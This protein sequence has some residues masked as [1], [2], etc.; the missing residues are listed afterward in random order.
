MLRGGV[1]CGRGE[2]VEMVAQPTGG[3][4]ARCPPTS[5]GRLPAVAAADSGAAAGTTTGAEEVASAPRLR[6]AAAAGLKWRVRARNHRAR[7]R[8]LALSGTACACLLVPSAETATPPASCQWTERERRARVRASSCVRVSV[9]VCA[10]SGD[11]SGTGCDLVPV[12]CAGGGGCGGFLARRVTVGKGGED[13]VPIPMHTRA[14]TH[15]RTRHTLILTNKH[16][17][18]RRIFVCVHA[19]RSVTIEP[20]MKAA[21]LHIVS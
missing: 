6:M 12:C 19:Y 18:L 8:V 4:S 11:R 15:T 2:G 16:S 21:F 9:F 14:R 20:F 5:T 13:R 10:R 17:T 7:A 1:D 3:C